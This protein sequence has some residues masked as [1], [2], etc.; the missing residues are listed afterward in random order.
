MVDAL[1]AERDYFGVALQKARVAEAA[2]LEAAMNI[3]D[4]RTLRLES[5][6]DAVQARLGA[7]THARAFFE[8]TVQPG[9]K[10]KLWIDLISSVVMEPD[11]RS[12]RLV[13]DRENS[14]ENVFETSVEL[15]MVNFLTQYLAHRVVAHDK[16][17]AGVSAKPVVTESG[18]SLFNMIYVWLTGCLF[19]VMTLLTIAMYMGKL[20]F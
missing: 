10:P 12:Y 19:G 14:I 9:V 6:R 1:M 13:Q 8:L 16:L 11:P 2:Q 15:E 7:N 20:H 5:L 4:A 17:L 3:R 18:Y